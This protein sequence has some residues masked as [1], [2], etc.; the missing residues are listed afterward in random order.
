VR[1]LNAADSHRPPPG[2][3]LPR[4][5]FARDA[6]VVAP[7][8]LGTILRV[9]GRNAVI[10]E[11]EAYTRDD[12]A[13]HTFRGPTARNASMFG[14]A[15]VLYVYF[16]YGM[17]HCVNIVTGRAGDGQGVLLRSVIVDGVDRRST[18]GPGRVCRELGIDRTFDGTTAVVYPGSRPT[19]VAV[20]PRIGITRAADWPRRWVV[21]ADRPPRRR[22]GT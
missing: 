15:G 12:P 17:H 22:S 8:L 10:T 11:V 9:G 4:S 6:T 18:T 21:V 14:P 19:E 7:E 16:V 13:S 1:A 5:F 2:R 3:R 20:T